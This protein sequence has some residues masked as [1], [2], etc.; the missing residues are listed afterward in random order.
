M[1]TKTLTITLEAYERLKRE[2]LEGESFSDVI[3]RL[4]EGKKG[5]LM[6]FA[7]AWKDAEE[8][9]KV[10]LEGR[11]EFDKNAKILS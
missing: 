2:K 5:N 9:E 10:I 11:K 6:E 8:I 4:T 3:I 7:G 1:P